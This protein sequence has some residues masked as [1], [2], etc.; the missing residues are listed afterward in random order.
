MYKLL[1]TIFEGLK[2]FWCGPPPQ[3]PTDEETLLVIDKAYAVLR[4]ESDW[5][6]DRLSFV[7][8]D[9]DDFFAYERWDGVWYTRDGSKWKEG[10][11]MGTGSRCETSVNNVYICCPAFS[12]SFYHPELADAINWRCQ[13]YENEEKSRKLASL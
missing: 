8:T 4:G 5:E 7:Q 1:K 13:K 10:F 3:R 2:S 12:G 11:F 9:Y 6:F